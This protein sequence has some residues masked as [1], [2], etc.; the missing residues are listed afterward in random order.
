MENSVQAGR[1]SRNRLA[2]IVFDQLEFGISKEW[3]D[4]VARAGEEVVDTDDFVAP[5][6]ETLTEVSTNKPR[7]AGD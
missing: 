3:F 5:I 4:I 2:N 1:V 6:Q 7:T